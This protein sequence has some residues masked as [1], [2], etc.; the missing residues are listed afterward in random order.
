LGKSLVGDSGFKRK[1]RRG[2]IGRE[3]MNT[4]CCMECRKRGIYE[5]KW[6][7]EYK[8]ENSNQIRER[9]QLQQCLL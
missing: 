7:K 1:W 2:I 9:T 8:E 6:S 3:S 5:G 4:Q